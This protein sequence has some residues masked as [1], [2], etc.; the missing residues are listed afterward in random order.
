MHL[1]AQSLDPEKSS[2][3]CCFLITINASTFKKGKNYLRVF[4]LLLSQSI[5]NS[6]QHIRSTLISLLAPKLPL[7]SQSS[8]SESLQRF[9]IPTLHSGQFPLVLDNK[10]TL[11]EFKG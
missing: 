10:L 7:V 2:L 1:T 5:R 3:S 4:F 8:A 11:L 6:I 9:N